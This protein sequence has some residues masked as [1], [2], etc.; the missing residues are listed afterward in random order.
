MTNIFTKRFKKGAQLNLPECRGG[1]L[2]SKFL[3]VKKDAEVA[4][5]D[6]SFF[7]LLM[8]KCRGGRD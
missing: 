7:Y 8:E 2:S 1:N 5:K 3:S 6:H 4:I